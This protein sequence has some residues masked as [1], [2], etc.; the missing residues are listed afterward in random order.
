MF[1]G[2]IMLVVGRF[3]G[4]TVFTCRDCEKVLLLVGWMEELLTT[5][6]NAVST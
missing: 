3:M 5:I 2:R 4:R 1:H 6:Y